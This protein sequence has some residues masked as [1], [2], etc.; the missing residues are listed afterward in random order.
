MDEY[1]VVQDSLES[2]PAWNKE[3][4]LQG[5]RLRDTFLERMV[6]RGISH[7]QAEI[8]LERIIAKKSG[9]VDRLHIIDQTSSDVNTTMQVAFEKHEQMLDLAKA[10]I[11]Q[12]QVAEGKSFDD[13]KAYSPTKTEEQE[14]LKIVRNKHSV[15]PD[16]HEIMLS[17]IEE[18][19]QNARL[20][21]GRPDLTKTEILKACRKDKGEW[22]GAAKDVLVFLASK[23]HI[24]K[25]GARY[26]HKA[27]K[28]RM[29]E[30]DFTRK[31][32]ESL[33]RGP[34]S[35]NGIVKQIGYDNVFGRKK[36]RQTL[37]FLVKEGLVLTNDYKWR[38]NGISS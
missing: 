38:Q 36:V 12:D 26:Y 8:Y 10:H 24:I 11:I 15:V 2:L 29:V 4:V 28:V 19:L 20:I 1:A 13:A 37:D 18:T 27:N 25:V 14:A 21:Y 22:R 16:K 33:Y 35:I 23:G 5:G 7:T 9:D 17:H 31:V 3:G 32:F 34:Q 6:E 30:S